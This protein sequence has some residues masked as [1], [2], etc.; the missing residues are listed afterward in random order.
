MVR[1]KP[2]RHTVG[3]LD[4]KPPQSSEILSDFVVRIAD[5][6]AVTIAAFD[7]LQSQIS[8]KNHIGRAWVIG[9]QLPRNNHLAVEDNARAAIHTK[10]SFAC[11]EV[12]HTHPAGGRAG[13]QH[14]VIRY[15][16][17]EGIRAFL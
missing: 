10:I 3:L 9:A 14:N 4:R 5:A 15:V 7:D 13:R 6:D 17:P 12:E 8:D 16:A 1:N 11:M 2:G